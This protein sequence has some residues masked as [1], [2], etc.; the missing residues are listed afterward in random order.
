LKH[1]FQ[2]LKFKTFKHFKPT[3]SINPYASASFKQGDGK[4][5]GGS[6]KYGADQLVID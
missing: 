5:R 2:P 3:Q 4:K 1:F 6:G